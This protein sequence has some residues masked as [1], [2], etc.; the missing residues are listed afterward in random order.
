LEGGTKVG[1]FF[2]SIIILLHLF[3]KKRGKSFEKWVLSGGK[4]AFVDYIV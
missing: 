4:G 3:V 2:L 1:L